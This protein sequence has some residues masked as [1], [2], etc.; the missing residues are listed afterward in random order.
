MTERA[1]AAA[2]ALS[3]GRAF[4]AGLRARGFKPE[5][6]ATVGA[7][8]PFDFE[9][10]EAFA[11][12]PDLTAAALVAR[13]ARAARCSLATRAAS[14]FLRACFAAFLVSFEALRA[15]LSSAFATRT[16]CLAAS[17]RCAAFT[18]SAPRRRTVMLS[19]ALAA[20]ESVLA[21]M[22]APLKYLAAELSAGGASC[23]EHV[24]I[25]WVP[26]NR[27]RQA[28]GSTRNKNSRIS[29]ISA[30]HTECCIGY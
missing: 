18:A 1:T 11:D 23:H 13:A 9:A 21:T 15:F 5:D 14:A 30:S 26:T 20:D 6:F 10:L 19:F 12:A 25:I 3:A 24:T 17:A 7:L 22:F 29:A 8:V 2:D 28:H 27:L 16:C 4:T